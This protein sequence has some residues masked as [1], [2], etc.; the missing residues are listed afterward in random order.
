MA[1]N[2]HHDAAAFP[3]EQPYG[4]QLLVSDAMQIKDYPMEVDN[5]CH[6]VTLSLA[7]H[8][9]IV[10]QLFRMKDGVLLLYRT[11]EA[12]RRRVKALEDANEALKDDCAAYALGLKDGMEMEAKK[13]ERVAVP[14]REPVADPEPR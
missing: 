5:R 7:T 12:G 1:S 9:T 3:R 11:L 10:S 13:H 8:M 6:T 4:E 2:P 14:E